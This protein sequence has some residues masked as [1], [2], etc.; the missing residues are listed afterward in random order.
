MAILCAIPIEISSRELDGALYLALHLAKR[1]IATFLGD[2]LVNRILKSAGK[3]VV[4]I[5]GD[6]SLSMNRA[7]LDAGGVVINL[8]PEGLGFADDPSEIL[9]NYAKVHEAT[10]AI[11][12]WGQK[13]RDII[14]RY[15]PEGKSDLLNITGYH[16][17][18]LCKPE[19]AS[20]YH[21]PAIV[22]KYGDGFILINTSFATANHKMG[23]ENY[24]K[25]LQKMAEWKVYND[26]DF[27][28]YLKKKYEYQTVVVE[29]IL[30]L[31]Q[32]LALAFPEKSIIIRPHPAENEKAYS[33]PL[34]GISNIFVVTEGTVREWLANAG[35][36]IHHDCTTGLE[37]LLMGRNV[38]Q[39]RPV[40]EEQFAASL[41]SGAGSPAQSCSDVID[42]IKV[43]KMEHSVYVDQLEQLRPYLAN[44]DSSA[45]EAL[46]NLIVNFQNQ[47]DEWEPS[48]L[49]RW[50]QL[51]CWRKY[52][53][54]LLR[55][56]QPG[57]NGRKVRYALEKFPKTPIELINK[58]LE[59]LR[60]ANPSLPK[61]RLTELALNTYLINPL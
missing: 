38:I 34:E 26:A 19:F 12:L 6:Q 35:A 61:V 18:D 1:G 46:V 30:E 7:V 52:A 25:M 8:N 53:S 41:L 44:I 5:D 10:T 28:S 2:Y 21:S 55:A 16:S 15:L 23:F 43:G 40:F 24:V 37:A 50:G 56:H 4:Y 58:K 57:R 22:D 20:Y 13:Q 29:S 36:V 14:A 47:L 11:C 9:E 60:R 48:P 45:C 39:Y 54:K 27:L 51:K 17:F 42:L 32:K 59:G 3:A 33:R 49:G 31:A